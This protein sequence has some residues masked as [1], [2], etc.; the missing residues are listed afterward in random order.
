MTT[1]PIK[2]AA[3]FYGVSVDTI[4]RRLRR[5]ELRGELVDGRWL[6]EVSENEVPYGSAA[7]TQAALRLIEREVESLRADRERLLGIIESLTGR[8]PESDRPGP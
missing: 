8:R 5:R 3:E 4:R 2:E 7:T 1:M 6:V